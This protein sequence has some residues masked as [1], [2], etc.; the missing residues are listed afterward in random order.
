[1]VASKSMHVKF[2]ELCPICKDNA[3]LEGKIVVKKLCDK[4][5]RVYWN[6]AAAKKEKDLLKKADNIIPTR[7]SK[8][9]LSYQMKALK[10][11]LRNQI[12]SHKEIIL[13]EKKE[14]KKLRKQSKSI[15]EFLKKEKE[16]EKNCDKVCG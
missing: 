6:N 2:S 7:N 8:N 9:I 3:N 10:K 11:T 15:N 1:M 13:K 4:C 16:S 14:I 5:K 12:K